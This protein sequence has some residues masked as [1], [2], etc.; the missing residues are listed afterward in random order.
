MEGRRGEGKGERA[1]GWEG[2]LVSCRGE[3]ERECCPW[4]LGEGDR[5]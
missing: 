2:E 1:E 4:Y 5:D 3:G